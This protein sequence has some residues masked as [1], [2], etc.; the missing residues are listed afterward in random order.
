MKQTKINHVHEDLNS[1]KQLEVAE[2][3][4]EIPVFK[5]ASAQ[6]RIKLRS[7]SAST[8]LYR[9]INSSKTLFKKEEESKRNS[10]TKLRRRNITQDSSSH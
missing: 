1:G 5:D 6:S 2:V 9:R 8:A 4:S 7:S 3:N 10:S